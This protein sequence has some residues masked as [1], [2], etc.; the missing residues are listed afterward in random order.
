[1]F[2]LFCVGST[3]GGL[4]V[5]GGWVSSI[6]S[7]QLNFHTAGNCSVGTIQEQRGQVFA[8]VFTE[9]IREFPL[10]SIYFT[11]S[12]TCTV[13]VLYSMFLSL[14]YNSNKWT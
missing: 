8:P 2:L 3:V 14:F 5:G 4:Y 1:M 11:Y 13:P 6:V 10:S 7:Q 9:T 12:R